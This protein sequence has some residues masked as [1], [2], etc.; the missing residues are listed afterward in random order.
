MSLVKAVAV[1]GCS[2]WQTEL[3]LAML[4]DTETADESNTPMGNTPEPS[5]HV[6]IFHTSAFQFQIHRDGEHA[7]LLV[8]T[9]LLIN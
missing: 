8:S 3:H 2:V 5:E 1:P 9:E 7:V 6:D 4:C